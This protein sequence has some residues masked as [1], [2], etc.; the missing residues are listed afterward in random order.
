MSPN[1]GTRC[2]A[3]LDETYYLTLI[4]SVREYAAPIWDPHLQKDI[5][6][7]ESVQW[8]AACFIKGDYHT[9]SSVTH[10]LQVLG[11]HELKDHRK[12]P[13]AGIDV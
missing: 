10:M 5:N 6:L 3:A 2:P 7:L 11:L 4:R 1:G 13:P 12:G 8:Q 9:T